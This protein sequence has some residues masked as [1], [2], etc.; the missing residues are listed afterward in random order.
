MRP[1]F[2]KRGLATIATFVGGAAYCATVWA[3]AVNRHPFHVLALFVG[4]TVFVIVAGWLVLLLD[5][6]EG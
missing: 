5:R 1:P 2:T 6:G 3:E 4:G